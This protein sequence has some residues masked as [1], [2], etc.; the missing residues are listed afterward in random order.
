[1]V[2]IHERPLVICRDF[3]RQLLRSDVLFHAF[4]NPNAWAWLGRAES[5]WDSKGLPAGYAD[6]LGGSRGAQH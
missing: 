3:F 6:R 1:M 5:R 2:R 4:C